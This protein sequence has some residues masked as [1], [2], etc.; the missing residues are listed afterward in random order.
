MY[1]STD[2]P[3]LNVAAKS[4]QLW[5]N[6]QLNSSSDPVNAKLQFLWY[7]M[8]NFEQQSFRRVRLELCQL[9]NQQLSL[10]LQ[11]LR[12][13]AT[14]GARAL[15]GRNDIHAQYVGEV[16]MIWEC[17][18]MTVSRFYWD[19]KV[20]DT[21]YDL[22]PVEIENK[23][24]FL[25][26]GTFDLVTDAH[27]VDCNHHYSHGIYHTPQGWRS[28]E[29]FV[30][31]TEVPLALVWKDPVVTFQ[32]PSVFHDKIEGVETT[33]TMLRSYVRHINILHEQMQRVINYT[34]SMSM[35]PGVVREALTGVGQGVQSALHGLGDLV[36]T[37]GS[38]VGN[39][40]HG[41]LSGP[42]QTFLTIIIIIAVCLGCLFLIYF[43]VTRNKDKFSHYWPATQ[44]WVAEAWQ[45]LHSRLNRTQSLH[46]PRGEEIE[47]S[48][49]RNTVASEGTDK[50][51][52]SYREQP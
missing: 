31:V 46:P 6:P 23:R 22:I 50:I 3:N 39:L 14:L 20:N 16:L 11:L 47:M 35:D 44:R 9:A 34:A 45:N 8:Q 17:R 41:F 36:H 21:C 38:E 52:L 42:V 28:V 1:V 18:N 32:A 27:P 4:E 7:K 26:P 13:D 40:V 5:P 12:I 51:C 2:P 29:G 48:E 15:L 33:I 19:Y 25:I 24:M 37:A 49:L 43:L 30:H 10:N